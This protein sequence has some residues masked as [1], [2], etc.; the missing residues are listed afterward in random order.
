LSH[1]NIVTVFDSGEDDGTPYLVMERLPGRTFAQEMAGGPVGVA[2]ALE[3]TRAV[4][5][6]LAAAHS[7]GI[8]HRDVKPGNVLLTASG[9]PKVADFGIAKMVEPSDE[10]DTSTLALSGE[11]YATPAYLAPERRAGAPATPATDLYAVGVMLCEA[12]TGTRP[13]AGAC[14]QLP[15][16]IPR[17][18]RDAVARATATDP[19]RR[20]SSADDMAAALDATDE[21]NVVPFPPR[22]TS[23]LPAHAGRRRVSGRAVFAILLVLVVVAAVVVGVILASG[24]E[25][26]PVFEAPQTSVSSP[27]PAPLDRAIEQLEQSVSR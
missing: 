20:F 13:V 19:A 4:L 1:P 12:V 25:E 24:G 8:L 21:A 7:A 14:L 5:S 15:D 18:V 9:M 27:L 3:V 16:A 2:R 23:T 10:A 6:A 11:L 22:A 26:E 17:T